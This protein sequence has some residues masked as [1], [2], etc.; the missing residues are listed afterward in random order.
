MN[1]EGISLSFHHALKTFNAIKRGTLNKK[2][3]KIFENN[4]FF[5]KINDFGQGCFFRNF[6]NLSIYLFNDYRR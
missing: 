2:Q 5:V 4:L 6:K 1:K 3:I